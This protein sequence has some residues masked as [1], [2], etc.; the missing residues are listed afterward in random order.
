MNPKRA[1]IA[2][3]VNV[4]NFLVILMKQNQKGKMKKKKKKNIQIIYPYSLYYLCGMNPFSMKVIN[5]TFFFSLSFLLKMFKLMIFPSQDEHF[6]I[7]FSFTSNKFSLFSL[8][9]Y[10]NNKM[11]LLKFNSVLF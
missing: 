7:T 4:N 5:I 3:S 10:F 9:L 1:Y 11:K 8:I 6:L 2:V